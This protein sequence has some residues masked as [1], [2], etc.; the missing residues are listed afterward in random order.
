VCA[1]GYLSLRTD[2][3]R[4]VGAVN[5][6]GEYF[7]D[8]LATLQRHCRRVTGV[9]TTAAR[10][11][12]RSRAC[13]AASWCAEPP[14]P[15]AKARSIPVTETCNGV[16]DNCTALWTTFRAQSGVC[17]RAVRPGTRRSVQQGRLPPRFVTKCDG[18]Q[19]A[20][21]MAT[22]PFGDLRRADNDCDG[23][24]MKTPTWPRTTPRWASLHLRSPQG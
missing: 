11:D 1:R 16:D 18:N 24:S 2:G 15:F 13:K 3:H 10:A 9:G 19:V 5:P 7:G 23:T 12:L 14:G 20:A 6:T 4:I 17:P 8:G 21:S 22:R